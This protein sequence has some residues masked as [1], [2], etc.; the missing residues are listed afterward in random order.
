MIRS[1]NYSLTDFEHFILLLN[2]M[3][4]IARGKADTVLFYAKN[5]FVFEFPSQFAEQ[6]VF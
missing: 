3:T 6:F 1:P 2:S 5:C 4:Q